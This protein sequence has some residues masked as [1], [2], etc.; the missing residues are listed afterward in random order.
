LPGIVWLAYVAQN[1]SVDTAF[2]SDVRELFTAF[3]H[4]EL[5]APQMQKLLA[6]P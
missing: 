2:E 4:L 3:Y 1:R 5:T 6:V